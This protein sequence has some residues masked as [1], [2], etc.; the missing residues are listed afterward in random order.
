MKYEDRKKVYDQAVDQW[1][2]EAQLVVALEE[3]NECGK[4]LCKVLR[5]KGDIAHLAEEVAD[6]TI[7]LEQV[8]IMFDINDDVQQEMD[9]KILRLEHRILA[10]KEPVRCEQCDFCD[11]AW[12][13][14]VRCLNEESQWA[15]EPVKLDNYCRHGVLR[16]EE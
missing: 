7:M 11:I 4:E 8:R 12:G 6:A 16:T 1:G 13:G 10:S 9:R 3:L 15:G 2:V 14:A 5:G